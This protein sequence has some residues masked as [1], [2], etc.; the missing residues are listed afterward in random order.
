MRQP[1]P[2]SNQRK[3][4]VDAALSLLEVELMVGTAGNVS[5]RET[6]ARGFLITLSAMD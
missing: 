1:L 2:N 5:V 3:H 6:G 4:V